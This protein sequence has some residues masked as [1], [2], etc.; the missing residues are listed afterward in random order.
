MYLGK[1]T[2]DHIDA[3][4]HSTTPPQRKQ[5][6]H[7]SNGE[8]NKLLFQDRS[9][10]AWYRFVLSYPPHLVRDYV[11]QFE[12]HNSHRVLDPFCGTGTTVVECK[13][14]GIP[15]VGIEANSLAYFAGHVKVDWY[16]G[17]LHCGSEVGVGLAKL[18]VPVTTDL[19]RYWRSI[20][21]T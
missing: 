13:K 7:V 12:L 15:S 2:M 18:D 16:P 3:A 10:H 9:A 21:R 17:N 8:I 6:R 11:A 5:A 19:S 1:N 20:H 4:R 14:L